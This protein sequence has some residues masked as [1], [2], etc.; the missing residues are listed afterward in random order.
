[1][2]APSAQEAQQTNHQQSNPLYSFGKLNLSTICWSSSFFT[3]GFTPQNM[4]S[5]TGQTPNMLSTGQTPQN[6]LGATP[7]NLLSTGATPAVS[8]RVSEGDN[9]MAG[10][11]VYAPVASPAP[12]SP[13]HQQTTTDI[14]PQ[15][16][17]IVR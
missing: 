9:M 11:P 2:I 12:P 13:A 15:L 17:N 10:G 6:M 16:Q 3:G 7:Q 14:I 4:L 8:N 5:T 1:M